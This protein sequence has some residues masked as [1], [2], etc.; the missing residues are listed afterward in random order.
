MFK[1]ANRAGLLIR[2]ADCHKFLQ[3]IATQNV[4]LTSLPRIQYTAFLNAQGRVLF[5][6][7][8]HHQDPESVL[9]ECD[10]RLMD[11]I[12]V[13]IEK[14]KLRAK[15]SLSHVPELN[16]FHFNAKPSDAILQSTGVLSAGEDPRNQSL[17]WRVIADAQ[18]SLGGQFKSN[19]EF[20]QWRYENG[21]AEGLDDYPVGALLPQQSNLDLLNALDYKKGC[22]VGQELVIRT[23]HKGVIR[24]RTLPI[25]LV[26]DTTSDVKQLQ[27]EPGVTE[28][29][30]VGSDAGGRNVNGKLISLCG[31]VGL[32]LIRLDMANQK[33]ELDNHVFEAHLPKWMGSAA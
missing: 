21:I 1:V 13:H 27:F 9:I 26:S 30:P 32:A 18:A 31:N 8:L 3:G 12:T 11:P 28:L 6:A 17:G 7:F 10:R 15:F 2:G 4:L 23:H 29:R 14:Y 20:R 19:D 5:D 24:K 33:F 22:Y 16:C 25:R